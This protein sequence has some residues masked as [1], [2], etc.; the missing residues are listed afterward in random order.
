VIATLHRALRDCLSSRYSVVLVVS[1]VLGLWLFLSTVLILLSPGIALSVAD[2]DFAN[3]WMA[4]RL[5][6]SDETGDLFGPQPV[7]FAHLKAAF[8]DNYPWHNWSYPPHMLL[9][10]WPLGFVGYKVAL[11]G[12]LA[13]TALFFI[14]ALNAFVGRNASVVTWI[15][16]SPLL[17][18]NLQFAQNGFLTAGLGLS[19]LA[20]RDKRPVVS[21]ILLGLL[22]VKPQ[23]GI[24]F[25]FLLIAERRWA[26]IASAAITTLLLVAASAAVF[27]VGAWQGYLAEVVP[28]QGYVMRQI[29]GSFLS[30]LP[31]VY[32]TLRNWTLSADMAL[33]LHCA[34]A[35]PVAAMAIAAFFRAERARDRSIIL[36][37]ATFLVT[38]YSVSYD[39][40]LFAAAVAL[41]ASDGGLQRQSRGRELLM[42]TAMLLPVLLL[43]LGGVHVAIAPLVI[44]AV[45]VVALREAGIATGW[46]RLR[47][48]EIPAA[49]R[50][51]S[52]AA[53]SD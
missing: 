48:D 35:L 39:L 26:M 1:T 21:G 4:A 40:G 38:P 37:V 41:M 27:G 2:K 49:V 7:Y 34:V 25:P 53:A 9:L 44:L 46:H 11:V 29:E 14:W 43:P 47:P 3:Y 12:F 10:L 20:F 52:P 13:V 15:A 24:L 51:S 8:G 50:P 17:V 42:M 5:V 33:L 6:L 31:S 23:L 18:H 16:A 28:Y 22:T 19:A 30:M 36:L 32:G 45:F